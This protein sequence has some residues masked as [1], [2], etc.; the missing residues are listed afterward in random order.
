MQC[1]IMK[2]QDLL[3]NKKHVIY[4]AS[5]VDLSLKTK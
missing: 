5:C 2:N 4:E 3:K 1:P